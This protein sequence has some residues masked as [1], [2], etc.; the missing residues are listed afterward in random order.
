MPYFYHADRAG[1]LTEGMTITLRPHAVDPQDA[2]L[3]EEKYPGGFS[4]HGLAYGRAT[5]P[6]AMRRNW[7]HEAVLELTRL[8]HAPTA[9]S[10]MQGFFAC[11]TIEGARSFGSQFPSGAKIVNLFRVEAAEYTRVDMHLI[12]GGSVHSAFTRGHDYWHG[13]ASPSPLWE[14]ILRPPVEIREIVDAV[15]V[16]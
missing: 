1:T 6:V 7:A 16:G 8:L 14:C 3:F 15:N 4:Q 10:R 12:P 13:V 2:R 9:I 11:E 5:V